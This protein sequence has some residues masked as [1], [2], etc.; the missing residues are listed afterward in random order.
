MTQR[1][2]V[3][4]LVNNTKRFLS[5]CW[6]YL[7]RVPLCFWFCSPLSLWYLILVRFNY[8]TY[9]TFLD[10]SIISILKMDDN[11]RTQKQIWRSLFMWPCLYQVGFKRSSTCVW[12]TKNCGRSAAGWKL[13]YFLLFLGVDIFKMIS[14]TTPLNPNKTIFHFVTSLVLKGAK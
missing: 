12:Y 4:L 8:T 7:V 2:L 9:S 5:L 10:Q 1:L 14:Y 3:R 11:G 13:K 6:S